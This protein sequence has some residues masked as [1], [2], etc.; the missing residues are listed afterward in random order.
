MPKPWKFF[1]DLKKSVVRQYELQREHSDVSS[2]DL[3]N[4]FNAVMLKMLLEAEEN[5]VRK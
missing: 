4:I 3:V 2:S 1:D 5:E